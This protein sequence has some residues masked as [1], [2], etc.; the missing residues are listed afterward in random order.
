LIAHFEFESFQKSGSKNR[1]IHL[2]SEI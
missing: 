2:K 1:A